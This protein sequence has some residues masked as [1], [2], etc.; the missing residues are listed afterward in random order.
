PAASTCTE[1]IGF[2]QTMQWWNS[3]APDRVVL[4]VSADYND[5]PGLWATRIQAAVA[6]LRAAKPS[7]QQIILQPVVGG[8]GAGQCT[9]E[10]RLVR[11]A[12][13]FPFIIQAIDSLQSDSE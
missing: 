4:N 1:V 11:A 2:S 12:Y 9:A 8:P 3:N 7:V 5:D 10:G 6:I 13:N